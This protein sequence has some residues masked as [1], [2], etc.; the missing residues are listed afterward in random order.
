MRSVKSPAFLDASGYASR[1]PAWQGVAKKRGTK[2]ARQLAFDMQA[3]HIQR[4]G[5]QAPPIARPDLPSDPIDDLFSS[6]AQQRNNTP[7]G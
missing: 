4:H 7:E 3:P 1:R 5:R 2:K 6:P